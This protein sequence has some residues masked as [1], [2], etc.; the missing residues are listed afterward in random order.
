MK[1]STIALFLSLF[2]TLSACA[3]APSSEEIERA[4]IGD[5]P[6]SLEAWK[7]ILEATIRQSLKDPDS[8]R[9]RWGTPVRSWYCRS[10]S[11]PVK[12]AWLVSLGVNARN[13]FG[14]YVGEQHYRV[15]F[16]NDQPCAIGVPEKV[17]IGSSW[18]ERL[19]IEEINGGGLTREQAGL[20]TADA[21]R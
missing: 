16:L 6:A 18:Q 15:F 3:V 12:F 2:L 1:R 9:F 19:T 7:P 11:S 17:W 10:A 8:G 5:P 14:G 21:A 13:S 4:D 20:V